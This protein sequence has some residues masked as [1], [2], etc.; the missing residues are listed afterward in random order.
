MSILP[1]VI[2]RFNAI[3]IKISVATF[4]FFRD[5]IN[6]SKIHVNQQKTNNLEKERH[7]W[8]HTLPD[9]NIY[10]KTVVIKIVWYWH[11]DRN[12]DNEPE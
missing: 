2:Y 8:R 7:S 1:K 6:N 11:K 5:R 12:I 10:F 9:F 3:P 4:F